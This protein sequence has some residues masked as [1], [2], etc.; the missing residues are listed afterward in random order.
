DYEDYF[1]PNNYRIIRYADILLMYAECVIETGGTPAEAVPYVNK[2]RQRP[3]VN[4]PALEDSPFANALTSKERFLKR[5][6]MERTLELCLEGWRWAGRKRW[7]ML[8]TQEGIDELKAR[9]TD[10]NNFVIGKHS[11]LPIPQ[12]EVDNSAGKMTQNPNY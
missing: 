1:A 6:Q 2:V 7:G 4:L 12:I 9:D 5:L 10:F 3:S 11:R 8:D